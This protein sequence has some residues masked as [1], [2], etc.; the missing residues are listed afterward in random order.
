MGNED[1][2]SAKLMPT[3]LEWRNAAPKTYQRLVPPALAEFN[4]VIL[5]VAIG[6]GLRV[7]DLRSACKEAADY[8]NPIEPSSI[9]GE[10]IAQLIVAS[11]TKPDD[12][13]HGTRIF[14]RP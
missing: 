2:G 5:R 6:Q 7:I 14:A 11:V 3:T 13:R 12:Q 9:G 4:D 8:A 1:R 10:K